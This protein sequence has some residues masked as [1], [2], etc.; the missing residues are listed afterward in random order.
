MCFLLDL[1]E[2]AKSHSGVNLVAAFMKILEDF[3][4]EHK[5]SCYYLHKKKGLT[6]CVQI[7]GITCD[8]AS[9]NDVMIDML[10]ELEVAFPGAAN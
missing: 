3:G 2:V 10:A 7:L 9:P 8:N 4:I 1:V 5:V 6:L